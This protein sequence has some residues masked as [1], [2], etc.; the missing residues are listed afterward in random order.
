MRNLEESFR[1]KFGRDLTDAERTF[2]YLAEEAME[3]AEASAEG[4]GEDALPDRRQTA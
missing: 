4:A 3:S 1:R 2:W